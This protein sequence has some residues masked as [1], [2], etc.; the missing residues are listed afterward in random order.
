MPQNP[1]VEAALTGEMYNRQ[2]RIQ[3]LTIPRTATVIGLGGT[4]FWTASFLAMSGVS[5][6][7]LI[8]DDRVEMS[9]LNRLPFGPGNVGGRKIGV[10]AENIGTIRPGI[11]IERHPTKIQTPADCTILRGSVFCCTDNLKSQQ[12]IC[13][14]CRKNDLPYQRI[15]YD[16]TLL[17]VS[18]GFPLS[19]EEATDEGGYTQTPSWVIPAVVAAGLGVYSALRETLCIMD[20]MGRLIIANSTHIPG[21]LRDKLKREIHTRA[22][23]E[24]EEDDEMG[25]CPGCERGD[26]DACDHDGYTHNDTV[27][28]MVHDARNESYDE[29]ITEGRRLAE[30]EREE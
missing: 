28:D 19:F 27:S 8:D 13:A 25:Y 18:T 1:Q 10:T 11:R 5:E 2:N 20:E 29:G 6:L 15:G 9:N 14:Y 4:G 24:I 12:M 23:Q 30:N 3:G 16:G 26:C 22:R 21:R 7:I 17:N